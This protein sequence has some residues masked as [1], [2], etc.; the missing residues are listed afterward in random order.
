MIDIFIS[1]CGSDET[2][3]ETLVELL[4][5]ALGLPPESIRCT[6]VDGYRLPS[7]TSVT[8][9]LREEVV[10]SRVFLGLITPDSILS[11]YVLLELGARWGAGL[12]LIP[13]LAS[14]ASANDLKGPLIN[15]HAISCCS[16]AQ[17][18][19]LIE[20]MGGKLGIKPCS[21]ASYDKYIKN[22]ARISAMP[23]PPRKE[24]AQRT[25]TVS[26]NHHD[27]S[28]KKNWFEGQLFAAATEVGL[29]ADDFRVLWPEDDDDNVLRVVGHPLNLKEI[30]TKELV[31]FGE[32]IGFRV[33]I[34]PHEEY[35]C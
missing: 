30:N 21:A 26:R 34:L 23:H 25:V 12:H 4:R 5:A 17:L 24:V 10:N 33:A 14:G 29:T 2:I 15:L 13:L 22:M 7:G 18:L 3:A 8:E 19:Q 35:Y 27:N 28:R 9:Q 31:G 32:D 16:E 6:S 11:A 1:H 20:E